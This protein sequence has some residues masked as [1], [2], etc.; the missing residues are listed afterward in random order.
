MLTLKIG[1]T[2]F[3][4]T[5]LQISNYVGKEANNTILFISYS[6]VL[7]KSWDLCH[8]KDIVLSYS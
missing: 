8:L 6:T 1:F 3:Y 7:L 2:K 4:Y 5:K